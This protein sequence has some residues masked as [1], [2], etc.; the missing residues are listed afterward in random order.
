MRLLGRVVGLGQLLGDDEVR[1][2]DAVAQQVGDGL[3][4]V[5]DGAVGVALNQELLQTHTD[6]IGD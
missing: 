3:L 1:D 2:V 6:Q 4:G 5:L